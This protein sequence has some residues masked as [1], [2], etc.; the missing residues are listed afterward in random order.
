MSEGKSAG[1][2]PFFLS[3]LY[4]DWFGQGMGLGGGG[5][6]SPPSAISTPVLLNSRPALLRLAFFDVRAC[7]TGKTATAANKTNVTTVPPTLSF[8]IFISLKKL[9]RMVLPIRAP[10]STPRQG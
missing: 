2:F 4:A 8:D 7:T 10:F 5:H 6:G 3:G 9:A 1:F